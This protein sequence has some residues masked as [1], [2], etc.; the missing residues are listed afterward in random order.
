MINGTAAFNPESE[1]NLLN[2]VVDRE[3]IKAKYVCRKFCNL[4]KRREKLRGA[5]QNIDKQLQTLYKNFCSAH[6][7]IFKLRFQAVP[8]KT[9]RKALFEVNNVEEDETCNNFL[10][11]ETERLVWV[12]E[13]SI[14]V[15]LMT[16]APRHQTEKAEG[17]FLQD[18][19]CTTVEDAP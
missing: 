3:R 7:F 15:D 17:L 10:P 13:P 12:T 14:K 5:L 19:S 4:L 8:A 2:F 11:S 16:E 9:S 6:G 18:F 1:L